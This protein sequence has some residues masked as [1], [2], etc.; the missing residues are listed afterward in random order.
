MAT[1]S[2]PGWDDPNYV[3]GSTAADRLFGRGGNDS[4]RGLDGHDRL[5]GASGKD[6]LIGG[7]GNDVLRG[8]KAGGTHYADV[9]V[10]GG[11]SG[12]D[13]VADFDV[14]KDLLQIW[15][16][17]NGIQKAADVLDHAR[18]KGKDVV[19]DLGEGSKITLKNV[20]LEEL[21]KN[22]GDHFHITKDLSG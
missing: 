3:E 19:I 7:T 14:N 9:F 20:D 1:I 15:K 17:L 16:G 12:K 6:T 4:I 10:F 22:P 18:Q 13:V 8:D 2:D 21:K 5:F 11:N